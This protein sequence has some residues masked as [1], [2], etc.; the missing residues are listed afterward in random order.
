MSRENEL[1]YPRHTARTRRFTFGAP[2]AFSV[3]P[4]GKRVLY[5]R[6]RAG[7]DPMTCLWSLD[8][9]SGDETLLA[10]PV[11]LLG[12]GVE[13]LP[14]EERAR[15]ER[16]RE[17]AGGIVG[18]ATDD[19]ADTV[20]FAL[21]GRPYVVRG[22]ADPR[23]VTARTPVVDPRIDPTGRRIGY[24]HAGA[25]RVADIDGDDRALADPADEQAD[26]DDVGYGLAEFVAA[27]EMSRTR[28]FWWAPDGERV[29]VARVDNAPVRRWY[30]AD[31]AH[32]ERP[33]VEHP[34]PAAGTANA[35]V[36]LFVLG[37][38]GSRVEVR[39]DRAA[40]EYL[41]QVVW[42]AQGPHLVVQ[43]RD[44]R[45]VRLLS[46]DPDTGNTAVVREDTDPAW[47]ELVGGVPAWAGDR[48]VW[49]SDVDGWRRL[50]VDG[51]PVTPD[52]LQVR[53]VLAADDDGVL[54]T[55][56]TEPTE[57]HVHA[58]GPDG[59][60]APVTDVPGVHAAVRAAGTT[61]VTSTTLD[62]DLG[63]STVTRADLSWQV[64][65]FAD[66]PSVR[67]SVT[68]IRTGERE[69][70]TAVLLPT[71]HEPGSARLPVLL[72]PYGG[73][74]AQRVLASR[75]AFYESQWFADQGFAVVVADGRGTPGRGAAWE[76]AVHGDLATP[77]LQDQV[78]ALHGA[79]EVYPDLD[80]DRVGIRGWSFGGYLA[81]LAVLR[82]PD[83]FRV[84]VAG[85]PVTD[86]SLY[87]TH[88]QE[89]YLG[90]PVTSPETYRRSSIID[91]APNLTRPLLI[92]HGLVDD[93]VVVAHTLR[94]SSALLA[95]GRPHTVLPL[96]GVT[97]MA[98]QETVAE[99][100][101]LLQVRFLKDALGD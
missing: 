81:A 49:V 76:R 100:L 30:I 7:D 65:S 90:D 24:V 72:D 43:S 14:P 85:A 6:S 27:E 56:S 39:W 52:G 79:A 33:P 94:L 96:S 68:L 20:T 86:L 47:V 45:T 15:R 67:P 66:T 75:R 84:G 17:A 71:G 93:N 59:S 83:V 74:H 21:G 63:T 22:G 25:F 16:M 48:L 64:R 19:A 36:R 101:L 80:L 18:Y 91:D 97:H 41:A 57:V 12:A 5:L 60:V 8:V 62:A 78:D 88:Y 11:G 69:L 53:H 10:D 92:I 31:P 55:A 87:D 58:W 13:D 1:S 61:V 3:T 37:L 42:P 99:N 28:G 98:S 32:P 35:D 34:Y 77:V 89:R 54:F 46:V 50:V 29:L 4:D 51:A 70:R 40:F 44:Q 2:R 38:D 9:E 73:P 23:P 95:A 26:G 82:R